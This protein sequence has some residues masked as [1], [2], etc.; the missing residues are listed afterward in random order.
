MEKRVV[1]AVALT[2]GVIFLSN[3]LFPT[4][5]PPLGSVGPD[6]ALV[7]ED[8]PGE[9]LEMDLSPGGETLRARVSKWT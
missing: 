2:I 4:P 3:V 1:L 8:S 7:A 9:G 5:E 6:S